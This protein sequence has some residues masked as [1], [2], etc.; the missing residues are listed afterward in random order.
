MRQILD[1]VVAKQ[2]SQ[3]YKGYLKLY[4]EQMGVRKEWSTIDDIVIL[5]YIVQ[6]KW[7]EKK[8]ARALFINVKVVF[9]H[10]LRDQPFKCIID[11]NFD[12]D[13]VV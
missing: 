12:S 5:V 4:S 2:L 13:L 7:S 6:E 1:K 10:I 3:F 9:D 8:I 11:L